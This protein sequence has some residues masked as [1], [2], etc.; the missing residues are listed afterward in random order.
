MQV[1]QILLLCGVI[2]GPFFIVVF[3]VEGAIRTGYDPMRQP[4]SALAI[5]ERGW[6]QQ[7]NFLIT[8][9]LMFACAFGLHS[10]LVAYGGSFWFPVLIGIYA[11]GLIGAGF[12]TTDVT[13]LP[14]EKGVVVKR[15]KS[16]I[17]HDLSSLPVFLALFIAF[18]VF[19]HL[20]IGSGQWGWAL[21]SILSGLAF[22]PG[23]V[24]AGMGF[25]GS[26][27]FARSGGLW[28][29][30]TIAT[31]WIWIALVAAHLL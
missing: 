17:F 21:Y 5:G 10:A 29:R 27:K 19:A 9:V 1:Q 25:S 20:A 14:K 2:A 11:L 18:F 8:G 15:T 7:A 31:G 28:Q 6:I 12:F 22:G 30:L 23:F 3:L 24:L 13:G 26:P 4:V 16:G